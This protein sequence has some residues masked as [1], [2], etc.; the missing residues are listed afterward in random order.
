MIPITV[1]IIILI[2]FLIF[3]FHTVESNDIKLFKT[4]NKKI[5]KELFFDHAEI[6]KN[7]NKETDKIKCAELAIEIE[8]N[9]KNYLT[10]EE[11][12]K[13][14]KHIDMILKELEILE[15]Q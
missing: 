7:L 3:P 11:T 5:C 1:F 4:N 14:Y 12:I 10:K 9:C 8:M 15:K 6:H 2:I 13:L